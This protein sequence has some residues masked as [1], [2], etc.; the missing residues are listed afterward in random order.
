[1][2]KFTCL[3]P[4]YEERVRHDFAQQGLMELLGAHIDNLSP[5]NC[6]VHLPFRS[7]VSQQHGF[8]HA[9]ATAAVADVA[10]ACASF[11]LMP[12]NA[13]VL[14]V[15]FKINFLAKAAGELLVA[16]GEVKRAG[17][18]LYV[19]SIDIS[20]VQNGQASLCAT[21]LQTTYCWMEP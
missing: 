7:G 15:E 18:N 14:T 1:M 12:A 13:S 4:N 21:A 3:D 10:G 19:C 9:G 17:K 2:K 6:A 8:F 11:T 5:G 20:C 16:S